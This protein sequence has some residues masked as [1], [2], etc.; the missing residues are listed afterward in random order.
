MQAIDN[1]TGRFCFRRG[2]KG[3][4]SANAYDQKTMQRNECTRLARQKCKNFSRGQMR[5]TLAS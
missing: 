3:R 2:D 4:A 1:S 5:V